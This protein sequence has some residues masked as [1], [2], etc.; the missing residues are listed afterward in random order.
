MDRSFLS[1]PEVIAASRKFVCIRLATYEDKE[2]AAFLKSLW[3]GRSGE[4]EN[5]LFTI[6]SPDGKRTLVHPSRSPR[7]EYEDAGAMAASL[8]RI[9]GE[10]ELRKDAGEKTPPLPLVANVRLALDVAACDGRPLV[11]LRVGDEAA[12]KALAEKL[13]AAAWSEKFLG[14]FVFVT[15]TSLKELEAVEGVE[16]KE[17]LV[18]I[19]PD[20]FGQKGKV[21]K[22]VGSEVS[23]ERLRDGLRSALERHE[24]A[25]KNAFEHIRAGRREEVF[26]ETVV[27]VTDP[28]ELRAREE[29]RR[30]K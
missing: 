1:Q 6:L 13:T 23:A 30:K 11:V 28:M 26:W 22:Q 8:K 12:R 29:G 18:V 3:V 17:G 14:Q 19:E 27:P 21:L 15:A 2:E 24:R 7:H 20:R 5:T 25:E 9:A 16:A 10:H 4:V